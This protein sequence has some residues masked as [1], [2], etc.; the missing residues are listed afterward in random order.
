MKRLIVAS[1]LSTALALL[2]TMAHGQG[3]EDAKLKFAQ[4]IYK[5]CPDMV[6][7]DSPQPLLSAVV[8]IRVRLTE[9]GTWAG[10]VLR[11]NAIRPELTR[12]ALDSVARLPRSS[13]MGSAELVAAL[14][15]EGFVETWLFQS[16]GRFALRTLAKPQRDS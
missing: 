9:D 13:L 3:A 16:D 10:E 11:D 1:L 5:A 15:R 12:L 2:S 8:V 6:H 7:A 4:S 14:Q